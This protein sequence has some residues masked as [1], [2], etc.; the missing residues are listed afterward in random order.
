VVILT[1]N[2]GWE[3]ESLQTR[4]DERRRMRVPSQQASLSRE[5]IRVDGI[6]DKLESCS[7]GNLS[8]RS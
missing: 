8:S 6:C 4:F 3:S 7:G 5:L 1:V 2:L